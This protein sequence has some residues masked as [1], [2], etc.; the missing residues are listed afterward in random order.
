[1]TDKQQCKFGKTYRTDV[2]CRLIQGHDGPCD[3]PTQ[4]EAR[5]TSL[6]KSG[7][8]PKEISGFDFLRSLQEWGNAAG[9]PDQVMYCLERFIRETIKAE[10]GK[11]QS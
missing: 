4:A 10:I 6:T 7:P 8:T 2:Q 1:M 9:P 11:G 3:F 5:D